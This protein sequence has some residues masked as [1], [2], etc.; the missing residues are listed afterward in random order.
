MTRSNGLDVE[1]ES[2]F[3]I[4]LV[5]PLTDAARAWIEDHV[6]PDAQHW[7]DAIVV[8]HRFVEPLVRGMEQDDLVV[9]AALRASQWN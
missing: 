2:H 4:Y 8:E 5:R 3:T 7:G 9:G 6:D 1:V